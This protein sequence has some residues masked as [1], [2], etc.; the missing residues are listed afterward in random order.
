[1]TTIV[2]VDATWVNPSSVAYNA[3][4]LRLADA[5]MFAG[6]GDTYGAR[7]GIVAHWD[8]SLLVSVDGSDVV[9]VKAGSVV[10][11][12]TAVS[13][14]G[15]W[16][17]GIGSDRT[18]SLA[19]RDATNARIDLVVFRQLDTDVVGS[20]G[21]YTARL[22]IITGTPSA[23]PAVPSLPTMAVELGRINVPASGGGAASAD[24]T[25]RTFAAALGGTITVPT[26][27]QLPAAATKWQRARA[28]DTGLEY[29]W[30]GSAWII[31]GT[32]AAA[33]DLF[34]GNEG[35]GPFG[36]APPAGTRKIIKQGTSVQT[37]NGAGGFAIPYHD[38]AF[39]N[40]IS[41]FV[42]TPGDNA[43]AFVFAT[44][45]L[46]NC[47]LSAWNGIAYKIN[48]TA[49]NAIVSSAIRANY[50]AIGW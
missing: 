19:A 39:P 18:A 34:T 38:G 10:I 48:G 42:V 23:T 45:I 47:S 7:G 30:T 40:G 16:R 9:T 26:A 4:E 22:E 14:T 21:A 8:N 31:V 6:R 17:A 12:G 46:G 27:S 28:L 20:H 2:D 1:M 5:A 3:S 32:V 29:S 49:I 36:T 50:V 43:S 37:T 24:L 44:P 25:K 11:P 13:G 35:A 15:V 41:S 33:A